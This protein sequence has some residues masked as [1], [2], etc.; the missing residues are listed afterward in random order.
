MR[1]PRHK[2]KIVCTIGPASRPQAV[3]K[4]LMEGGMNVARLNFSHGTFEEHSRDARRIRSLADKLR[5]PLTILVDLPGPKIRIG[6]LEEEPLVLEK[7]RSVVLTTEDVPGT[8]SQISVN[9]KRLPQSVSKGSLIYLNDGFMQLRVQEVSEDRVR[10]KVVVGG[11][12]LSHKGLNLPKAELHLDPVT[13]RDLSIV[14]F[15]LEEGLDTF[16]VSFVEKAE[17]IE[18]VR[19]FAQ[20]KGR[21]V[22]VVAKIERSEAVRNIDEVLGA[23]D[24]IIVARGDLGVQM[25]IEEVPSVQ[26]KLILKANLRA[27]PVVTATQMLESMTENVRPTRAEVTDVA[28]AILDGTDAVMLSEETAI[29]RHPVAALKMMARIARSIERQRGQLAPT[30]GL[31]ERIRAG[32]GRKGPSVDDV[33]SL[34]VLEASRSLKA[35]YI[36]TPTATGS[37]PRRV[38]RFKP[39]CWILSFSDDEATRGFLAL[40]Y[41]VYPV[42]VSEPP[43]RWHDHAVGF[44]KS[45]KLARRGD[46]VILTEG[47]SSVRSGE[48]SSLRTISIE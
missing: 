25:P 21:S 11:P 45:K 40:S 3:L 24:A 19:D 14:E 5:I 22:K 43:Q 2:T 42:L 38:S 6:R 18:R 13:S 23:A 26:K 35:R 34:N 44:L 41:G 36:L 15:C 33:V 9:Y 1:L 27:R 30:S 16:C 28:N 12:L 4:E 32:P 39:D 17:D 47:V 31:E 37:T 46:T 7:G 29:G 48:T 8:S 10:C 20:S